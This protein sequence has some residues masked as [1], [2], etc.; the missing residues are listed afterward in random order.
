MTSEPAPIVTGEGRQLVVSLDV[1][2]ELA[3]LSS[4]ERTDLLDAS[5][6]RRLA[7][8]LITAADAV[9]SLQGVEPS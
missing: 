7:E 1:T 3:V 4:E 8:E 9:D 5:N 2:D 6:A